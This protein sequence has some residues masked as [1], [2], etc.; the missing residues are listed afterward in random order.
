MYAAKLLNFMELC[1]FAR[2]ISVILHTQNRLLNVFL[3]HFR[4]TLYATSTRTQY[5]AATQA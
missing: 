5:A 1:L 4:I 2:K 3:T